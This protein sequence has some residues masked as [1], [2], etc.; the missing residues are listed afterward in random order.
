LRPDG[1]RR[2]ARDRY[3]AAQPRLAQVMGGRPVALP[4]ALTVRY[5]DL[6]LRSIRALRPDL[7]AVGVLPPVHRAPAY[8]GVHT[9]RVPA[10]T[11][12]S[13]WGEQSGVPMLDLASLVESHVLGGHG[14]PDG[15]HWGWDGHKIVGHALASLIEETRGP[16]RT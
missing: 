13:R 2:W 11:A 3:L 5:L 6:I 15:M 16:D 7:P 1:L 4:P 10:A 8:A 9:G 12:L 14:N